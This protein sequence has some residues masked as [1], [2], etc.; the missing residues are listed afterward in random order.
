MRGAQIVPHWL[1]FKAPHLVFLKKGLRVC[2]QQVQGAAAA[3]GVSSQK[4]WLWLSVPSASWT[5]CGIW[6][7][8]AGNSRLPAPRVGCTLWGNRT[9]TC[10][11]KSSYLERGWSAVFASFFPVTV[12]MGEWG[13]DREVT[14][15][16][17]ASPT[18]KS[19]GQACGLGVNPGECSPN[20]TWLSSA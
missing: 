17:E 15:G 6:C 5:H 11:L 14:G 1:L 2:R 12:G 18:P 10:L 4:L 7:S 9:W 3:P 19:P 13:G 20:R 16:G 8:R